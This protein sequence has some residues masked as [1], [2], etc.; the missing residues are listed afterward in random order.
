MKPPTTTTPSTPQCTNIL[1]ILQAPV[2]HSG[3]SALGIERVLKMVKVCVINVQ[4]KMGWWVGVGG[5]NVVD[6]PQT[7]GLLRL[8]VPS[9]LV[10]SQRK[11][12]R[13]YN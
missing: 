4:K 11:E 12:Q 1:L 13:D 5:G 3:V 6:P 2:S 9:Q 10:H 8:G 7:L